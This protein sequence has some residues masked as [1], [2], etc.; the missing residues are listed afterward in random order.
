MRVSIVSILSMV[1]DS[2]DNRND[3]IA[4]QHVFLWFHLRFEHF[5]VI[6]MVDKILDCVFLVCINVGIFSGD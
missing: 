5:I 4:V 6:S 2:I 3:V 1:D